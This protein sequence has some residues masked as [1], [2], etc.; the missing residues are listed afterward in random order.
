MSTTNNTT[1]ASAAKTAQGITYLPTKTGNIKVRLS[2]KTVG[3]IRE[4]QG[5]FRYYP[6][7]SASPGEWFATFKEIKA[8][9]EAI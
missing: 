7:G 2:R 8:S 4:R 9:L 1:N 5:G 3:E 6:K